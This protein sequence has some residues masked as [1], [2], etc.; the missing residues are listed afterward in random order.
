MIFEGRC[1]VLPE[2]SR[3][4]IALRERGYI[5]LPMPSFGMEMWVK[6]DAIE[7]TRGTVVD[8]VMDVS[9]RVVRVEQR[10]SATWRKD[11]KG[12]DVT[13]QEV[14]SKG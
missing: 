6:P 12:V 3:D 4:Q 14:R 7:A 9:E 10:R 2:R 11:W 1:I 8:I 13:P 5:S